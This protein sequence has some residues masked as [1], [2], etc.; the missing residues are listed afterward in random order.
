MKTTKLA[1]ILAMLGGVSATWA[2]DNDSGLYIGGGVGQ[3]NVEVDD[4]GEDTFDGDDD[5]FKAFI[6][7]RFN[8]YVA[9]E[10]DAYD[11]GSPSDDVDG[12]DVETDISGY[13]PFV[14]G[15][16]PLGPIELFAKAGYL[17]YDY[18]VKAEGLGGEDDD[19]NDFVYGVGAGLTLF[20][21]LH[22][23]LEYEVFDFEEAEEADAVWLSAAWRF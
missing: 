21:H 14:I 22:A 20:G 23:R 5:A 11:F 13:A 9:V 19:G 8:P 7:W 2:A 15:T 1:L 17:F 3:F 16:L 4:V 10:L 6:G 18:E 12:F